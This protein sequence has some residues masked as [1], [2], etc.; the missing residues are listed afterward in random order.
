MNKFYFKLEKI[1][2]ENLLTEKML[3]MSSYAD[4]RQ[5]QNEAA[6]RGIP[7]L[8]FNIETVSGLI[9][10]Q[11]A[12]TLYRQK[13]KLIDKGRVEIILLQIMQ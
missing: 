10:R 6:N 5:V 8:N 1:C 12:D 7:L 13:R 2:R 9:Q 3:I 4:G 11:S